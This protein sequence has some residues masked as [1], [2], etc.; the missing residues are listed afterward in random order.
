MTLTRRSAV[1]GLSAAT[2]STASPVAAAAKSGGTVTMALASEPPTL[3]S[4]VASTSI[5]LS[6]RTTEGLLQHDYDLTAALSRD[7]LVHR[8][9]RPALH[10][11]A[12]P[13]REMA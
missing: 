5:S 1:A 12:A 11:Q 3:L 2:L 9:G 6:G 4:F 10:V 8:S 13:R 7:V